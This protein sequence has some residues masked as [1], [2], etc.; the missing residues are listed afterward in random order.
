MTMRAR[1]LDLVDDEGGIAG[2]PGLWGFMLVQVIG[3]VWLQKLGLPAG[4]GKV[5]AINLPLILGSL[6]VLWLLNPSSVSVD[7]RRTTMFALFAGV[8]IMSQVFGGSL[9]FS[10]TGLM[11]MLGMY[12]PLIFRWEIRR[13]DYLRVMQ[14]FQRSMF[15]V[16]FIVF[17]LQILQKLKGWHSWPDMNKMVPEALLVSGFNYYRETSFNSGVLSPH[18]VVFLEPSIVSQFLALAIVIEFEFFKR[19]LFLVVFLPALLLTGSG[20]GM[21]MLI[22]VAPMVA[23]KLP[24]KLLIAGAVVAVIGGSVAGSMGLLDKYAERL[25]EVNQEGTSGYYRF[26]LPFQQLV[27]ALSTPE[28]AFFGTGAGSTVEREDIATVTLAINKLVTEY[29]SLTAIAFFVLYFHA[30]F[31]RAPSRMLAIVLAVYYNL[32]GAGLSVPIYAITYIVL[33]TLLRVRDDEQRVSA[34][35][36]NI[37]VRVSSIPPPARA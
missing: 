27:E 26:T 20:T 16:A 13:V 9:D 30:L 2:W 18:A 32:C 4:G 12:V 3:L 7:P 28:R 34:P 10:P 1:G 24:P 29:G 6:G 5:I 15:V 25:A 31:E 21:L 8:A 37:R 36:K 11:L 22:F 17:A 23:R 14:V 35:P 33:G 19:N